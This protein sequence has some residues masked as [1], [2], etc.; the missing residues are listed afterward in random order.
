MEKQFDYG[1]KFDFEKKIDLEIKFP[2]STLKFFFTFSDSRSLAA[3]TQLT[4][5]SGNRD[6]IG[7]KGMSL[8]EKVLVSNCLLLHPWRSHLEID[9]VNSLYQG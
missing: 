8:K 1:T 5:D 4:Q 9:N 7:R 6:L 2:F 3:A